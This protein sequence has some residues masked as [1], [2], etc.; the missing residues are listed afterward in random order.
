[1]IDISSSANAVRP[2]YQ[3]AATAQLRRSAEQA[4]SN[5][6]SL[7]MQARD[8][9]QRVENATSTARAV[10]S[11]ANQAVSS[12][13]KAK[14]DVNSFSAAVLSASKAAPVAPPPST[15]SA[16]ASTVVSAPVVAPARI[17]NIGQTIGKN[18]NVEA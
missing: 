14:Q 10:D 4:Q 9:W 12:A 3:D 16:S 13:S 1:M 17:N 2:S 6:N 7:Q 18:F 11:Q 5:A 8:A 15:Y